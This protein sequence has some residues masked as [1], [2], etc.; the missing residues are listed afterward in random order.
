MNCFSLPSF[1][2][3]PF[4]FSCMWK[5]GPYESA[6][7]KGRLNPPFFCCL[8]FCFTHHRKLFPSF[9]LITVFLFAISTKA[10][11]EVLTH[12]PHK[13]DAP[14]WQ[15]Y[16]CL[17]G[18]I[19]LKGFALLIKKITR[20]HITNKLTCFLSFSLFLSLSL[21]FSFIYLRRATKMR[22]LLPNSY[23]IFTHFRSS[24]SLD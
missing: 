17:R 22:L 10:C 6:F 20:V 9:D 23:N 24:S 1:Y 14:E 2:R 13:K 5:P 15:I 3:C 4:I 19:D 18:L 8:V 12:A 21:S 11:I 7:P 16:V